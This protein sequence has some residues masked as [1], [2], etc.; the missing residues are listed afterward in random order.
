MALSKVIFA[1]VLA[2]AAATGGLATMDRRGSEG[3][4]LADLVEVA[5]ED[6]LPGAAAGVRRGAVEDAARA[7]DAAPSMVCQT[8]PYRDT[9]SIDNGLRADAGLFPRLDRLNEV[10]HQCRTGGGERSRS[11]AMRSR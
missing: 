4:V 6:P 5:P 2:D 10:A 8:R 11:F 3:Q 7:D 1:T 9:P